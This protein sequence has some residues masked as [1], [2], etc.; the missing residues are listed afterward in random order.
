MALGSGRGND[1]P[2]LRRCALRRPSRAS[3]DDH[4]PGPRHLRPRGFLRGSGCGRPD[5][6]CGIGQARDGPGGWRPR[7][8]A[9][10]QPHRSRRD[11]RERP[12]VVRWSGR[13]FPGRLCEVGLPGQIRE[14]RSS[15][16]PVPRD[17]QR[18]SPACTSRSA[19]PRQHVSA[20]LLP[21]SEHSCADARVEIRVGVRVSQRVE[22]APG[23]L[24]VWRAHAH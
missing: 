14:P 23:I 7:S 15:R 12:P 1:R 19:R 22:M 20:V 5:R 3:S 2:V 8:L 17:G 18:P 21:S 11:A 10:R 16:W 6:G 4:G 9:V 24:D 13:D